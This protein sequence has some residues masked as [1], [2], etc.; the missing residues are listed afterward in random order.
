MLLE[1]LKDWLPKVQS[2]IQK[3]TSKIEARINADKGAIIPINLEKRLKSKINSLPIYHEQSEILKAD[4]IEKI[5]LWSQN[6]YYLNHNSLLLF[7]DLT[8]KFHSLIK[9]SICNQEVKESLQQIDIDIIYFNSDDEMSYKNLDYCYQKIEEIK[10]L[11]KKTVIV[12][13]NLSDYFFRSV[14]GLKFIEYFFEIYL[15]DK[16]KFWLIGCHNWLYIFLEK[17]YQISKF[18]PNQVTIESLSAENLQLIFEPVLEIMTFEWD[19]ANIFNIELSKEKEENYQKIKE[20]YFNK[21]TDISQGNLTIATEIFLNSL[22]YF[23]P[24]EDVPNSL[25]YI[26]ITSPSLPNLPNI[27]QNDRYLLYC[28]GLHQKIAKSDLISILAEHKTTINNQIN[29]LLQVGLIDYQNGYVS[30]NYLHYYKL[31]QNLQDNRFNI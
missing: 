21:L 5:L 28:V 7:G 1:K 18:F 9:N 3:T 15:E 25:G 16:D 23:T 26:K 19:N 31:Y 6:Y 8:A 10:S 20:D 22:R 14:E 24:E 11:S 17:V 29:Y 4:F 12:I 30:L 27:T 2:Q 13:E